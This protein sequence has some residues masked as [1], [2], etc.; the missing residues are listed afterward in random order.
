MTELRNEAFMK[1]MNQSTTPLE[2]K[3]SNVT[4]NWNPI[5]VHTHS[6]SSGHAY[7]TI[8]E[9]IKIAKE[10]NLSILGLSDHAPNMPG[11][12]HPYYFSNLRVLPE[13]IDGVRILKGVELNVLNEAGDI[14]LDEFTLSFLDYAIASLHLPCFTD[15]GKERNT[16]ALIQA[17]V[18][19]KII[20]IAHPDDNRLP[21]NYERLVLAAKEN[22]VL[23]EIN[24][25]SLSPAAF[26]VNAK[27][28]YLEMLALCKKH[29]VHVIINS[30]SHYHLDVGNWNYAMALIHEIDFPKELIIN[31][32]IEEFMKYVG[33]S[34]RR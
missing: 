6:I 21:V 19:K 8:T 27:E 1:S 23:L 5:D 12:T 9:N 18:N 7:S 13:T 26:R 22:N 31:Y 28:N 20:I 25:S 10:R 17:M 33:R 16:D 14:D 3:N 29:E 2:N 4:D 11:S 30:D 15:L 24:N 32:H 34:S